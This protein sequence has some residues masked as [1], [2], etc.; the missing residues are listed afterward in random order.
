M[1]FICPTCKGKGRVWDH[2]L[3]LGTFGLGYLIDGK[4]VCPQCFG[5]G[6]ISVKE[7]PKD[8]DDAN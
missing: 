1:I 3:G 5:K 4:E 7:K 8:A 6:F 2:F